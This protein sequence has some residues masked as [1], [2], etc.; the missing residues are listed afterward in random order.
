MLLSLEYRILMVI[1][2]VST[3]P[4]EFSNTNS[5]INISTFKYVELVI[6]ENTDVRKYKKLK[7]I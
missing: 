4:S 5:S 3:F 7:I 6:W 2:F 1:N